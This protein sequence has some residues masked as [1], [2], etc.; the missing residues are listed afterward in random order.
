MQWFLWNM[1]MLHTLLFWL[2]FDILNILRPR[3][4]GCHFPD[5][6]FLSENVLISIKISLK[7][8]P[9]GPNN[10][11]PALVKIMAW[12]HPGYKPLSEPMMVS[13]LT[14]ICVTGPQWVNFTLLVPEQS[15][16]CLRTSEA[17][18]KKCRRINQM[19]PCRCDNIR[20]DNIPAP[21]PHKIAR[22]L[23]IWTWCYT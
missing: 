10:Y 2:W 9:M 12:C 5:D 18:L 8:V 6:I 19:N 17:A 3:Q 15:Y 23:D 11:I 21:L 4:N 16:D 20:C 13:L 7:F 14:H 1:H 22:L